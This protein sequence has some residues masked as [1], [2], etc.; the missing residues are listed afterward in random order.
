MAQ[1]P[2]WRRASSLLRLHHHTP[3]HHARSNSSG[4]VM[5]PMQ[6]PL[7]DNTQHSQETDLHVP[8]G[9]RTPT[10]KN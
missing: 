8:S 9:I 4:R 3:T 2:Y 7:P 1:N 5:S 6:R 10:F